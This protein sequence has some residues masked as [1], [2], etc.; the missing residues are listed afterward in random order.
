MV[1]YIAPVCT[2][3]IGI[4]AEVPSTLFPTPSQDKDMVSKNL[5]V[6][7]YYFVLIGKIQVETRA[8]A[9]ATSTDQVEELEEIKTRKA[10][11]VFEEKQLLEAEMEAEAS[12]HSGANAD[13]R[14]EELKA[15]S[16]PELPF[17]R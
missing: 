7:S 10:T 17:T 8:Q 4:E 11:K 14:A 2:S 9:K 5:Y 3:L 6:T 15:C 1:L 12:K 13:V 16:V